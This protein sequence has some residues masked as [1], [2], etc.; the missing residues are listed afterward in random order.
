MATV[1]RDDGGGV[2]NLASQAGEAA[3]NED[4]AKVVFE[5]E[6]TKEETQKTTCTGLEHERGVRRG[7]GSTKPRGFVVG[8]VV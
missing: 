1:V 7:Q 8:D 4:L 5:V 2:G 3:E 6:K